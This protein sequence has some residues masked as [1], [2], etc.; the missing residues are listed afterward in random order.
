MVTS[1]SIKWT[2]QPVAS[3]QLKLSTSKRS[4]ESLILMHKQ[5]LSISILYLLRNRLRL[6]HQTYFNE[7]IQ[8]IGGESPCRA[9]NL[10]YIDMLNYHVMNYDVQENNME[11]VPIIIFKNHCLNILIKSAKIQ[12]FLFQFLRKH[13]KTN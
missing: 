4:N 3:H 1:S 9:N 8:F 12:N 13:Y 6:N 11:Q 5:I 7:I 10:K 2:K